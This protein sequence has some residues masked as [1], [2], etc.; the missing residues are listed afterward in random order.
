[1]RQYALLLFLCGCTTLSLDETE[2]LEM[3]RRN[4]PTFFDG[5]NY[6]QSLIQAERGLE[7]D[8]DDYK[9]NVIKGAVLLL[10]S[11]QNPKMLDQAVEVLARVYD[12]RSDSR[13]EPY[14]L[15][16]YGLARQKLGHR[17]F[18]EAIRAD[19]RAERAASSEQ[20]EELKQFADE[21]RELA[22]TELTKADELLQALI[23]RGELLRDTHMHRVHIA[24]Q[25]KDGKQ[26]EESAQAFFVEMKKEQDFV[27]SELKRTVIRDY[28]AQQYKYLVKLRQD[29]HKV[30]SLFADWLFRHQRFAEAAAQLDIVLQLDPTQSD[31]YYNRGRVRMELQQEEE[32]KEDFRRFLATSPL[33]A[34]SAKKT[35]ATKALTQ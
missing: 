26:L 31:E 24:F 5:G 12:W 21:Q 29:E 30:R 18:A 20:H 28:E 19:D 8:P 1:M 32:A 9:L 3:C 15:Y 22:T 10:A 33:P 2:R 35:F 14:E 11:E 6:G 13:H 16:Y 23:E 25:L 34:Y 7:I 17:H 27:E 4:A